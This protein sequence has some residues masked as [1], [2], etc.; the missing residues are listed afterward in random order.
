MILGSTTTGSSCA[1]PISSPAGWATTTIRSARSRTSPTDSASTG[2]ACHS[3][4]PASRR[5]RT[6]GSITSRRSR[7]AIASRLTGRWNRTP[8]LRA[9]ALLTAILF[10]VVV[11]AAAHAATLSAHRVVAPRDADRL[12]PL[13]R[14]NAGVLTPQ[15]PKHLVDLERRWRG[16]PDLVARGHVNWSPRAARR[17]GWQRPR[18]ARVTRDGVETTATPPDTLKVA[19][20]RIDFLADR[21]GSPSP[22]DGHSHLSRPAPTRPPHHPPP[23]HPPS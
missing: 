6:P 8:R 22:G 17:V 11:G 1:S 16:F 21:G 5:P 7:W 20:L 4:T 2:T 9:T 3:I 13:G 19:L 23:P 10:S 18:P 12:A 15:Q 14:L